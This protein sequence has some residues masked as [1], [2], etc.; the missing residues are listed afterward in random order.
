MLNFYLFYQYKFS[1]LH[2]S[3]HRLIH[4]FSNKYTKPSTS[5]SCSLVSPP[6]P[7]WP[8]PETPFHV[9]PLFCCSIFF[10]LKLYL[11]SFHSTLPSQLFSLAF[12]SLSCFSLL[13]ML[14]LCKDNLLVCQAEWASPP[15]T[16]L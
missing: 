8:H 11:C 3:V 16:A 15:Q 12:G 10:F 5:T 7:L 2:K 6:T 14:F 9:P 1:I 13:M 4:F